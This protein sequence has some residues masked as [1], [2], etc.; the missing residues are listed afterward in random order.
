MLKKHSSWSEST[1]SD[2]EKQQMLILLAKWDPEFSSTTGNEKNQ[3]VA[4]IIKDKLNLSAEQKEWVGDVMKALLTSPDQEESS[5]SSEQDANVEKAKEVFSN[6]PFMQKLGSFEQAA[7]YD[8]LGQLY[9]QK[10]SVLKEGFFS[11][12]FGRVNFAK[13]MPNFSDPATTEDL[14]KQLQAALK[15][16]PKAR[17]RMIVK[18]LNK[19]NNLKEFIKMIQPKVGEL[20]SSSEEETAAEPSDSGEIN[21]ESDQ[22]KD[23]I[24]NLLNHLGIEKLNEN[25][26]QLAGELEGLGTKASLWFA[27]LKTKEQETV[28]AFL[29]RPGNVMKLAKLIKGGT[30]KTVEP[31]PPEEKKTEPTV[32]DE[33]A[34]KAKEINK[35]NDKYYKGEKIE[36]L[37][38]DTNVL[39]EP[40]G[41]YKLKAGNIDKFISTEELKRIINNNEITDAPSSSAAAPPKINRKPAQSTDDKAR[42]LVDKYNELLSGKGVYYQTYTGDLV[43]IKWSEYLDG[44]NKILVSYRDR[45]ERY[46]PEGFLDSGHEYWFESNNRM[47]DLNEANIRLI[48]TLM[49]LV[50]KQMRGK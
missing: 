19:G 25:F 33:L 35:A 16:L 31:T 26:G 8:F 32:D 41:K 30:S 12:L 17:K 14:A 5:A 47:T 44:D 34:K 18:V 6:E 28:Q 40:T 22:E 50:R 7:F 38:P 2:K 4:D 45:K 13:A 43:G 11:R 29:S 39:N 27:G 15:A 10:D 36:Y 37:I 1:L 21:F 23:L 24:N 20:A 46:T 3:F 48:K 42:A 49:P 9:G